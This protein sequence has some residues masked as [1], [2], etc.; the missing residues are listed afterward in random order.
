MTS[1]LNKRYD[2]AGQ[3]AWVD[4]LGAFTG[5]IAAEQLLDVGARRA[6]A[7]LA[8]PHAAS[9]SVA[10]RRAAGRPGG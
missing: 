8:P 7:T 5:E 9:R 1:T 4:G 10:S 3:N 6:H 2:V